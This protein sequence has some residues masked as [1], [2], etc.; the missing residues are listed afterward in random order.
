[1]GLPGRDAGQAEVVGP[2]IGEMALVDGRP[3]CITRVIGAI[4]GHWWVETST[5]PYGVAQDIL[6]DWGSGR[7]WRVRPYSG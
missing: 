6:H 3:G 1:M 2:R 4:N 5:A 7:M